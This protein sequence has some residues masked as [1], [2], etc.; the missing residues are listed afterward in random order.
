MVEIKVKEALNDYKRVLS[1]AKKPTWDD[2]KETIR[3]CGIGIA[4]IGVIGFAFF[5]LFA[6]TGSY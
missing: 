2:L 6:L 5:L 1:V 4:V 3:V